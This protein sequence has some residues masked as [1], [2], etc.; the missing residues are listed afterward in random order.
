MHQRYAKDIEPS[1]MEIAGNSWITL[2]TIFLIVGTML[3]LALECIPLSF[4]GRVEYPFICTG[5]ESPFQTLGVVSV[6]AGIASLVTG[7]VILRKSREETESI[8]LK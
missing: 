5:F 7:I 4:C 6:G 1:R 8:I 2:A 3:I